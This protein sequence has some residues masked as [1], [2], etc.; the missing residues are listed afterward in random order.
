LI[1]IDNEKFDTNGVHNKY[2]DYVIVICTSCSEQYVHDDEHSRLY[3]DPS[4]HSK[5][6]L[7]L[8]SSND[9][10]KNYPIACNGCGLKD[11]DFIDLEERNKAE[12]GPWR[13]YLRSW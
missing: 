3:F 10:I 12:A 1:R 2:A 9:E 11:W 6:F 5:W 7:T 13:E 4:D 8:I